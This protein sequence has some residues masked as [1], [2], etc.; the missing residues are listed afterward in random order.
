M[1]SYVATTPESVV[2]VTDPLVAPAAIIGICL[3]TKHQFQSVAPL[4]SRWCSFISFAKL[5]YLPGQLALKIDESLM[6][7][8][9][10]SAFIQ[11]WDIKY[12]H[13]E[14]SDDDNQPAAGGE[15]VDM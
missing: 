8:I 5:P 4:P 9:I 15:E 13:E 3:A 7:F 11:L 10:F 14:D 1:G 12:L 2:S 6:C